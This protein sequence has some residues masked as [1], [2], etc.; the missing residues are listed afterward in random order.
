MTKYLEGPKVYTM[1]HLAKDK[2]KLIREARSLAAQK[3]HLLGQFAISRI[4]TGYPPSTSRGA[5]RAKCRKCGAEVGIDPEHGAVFGEGVED[6][7]PKE[8]DDG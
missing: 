4:V 8:S 5:L 7:C 3:N 2:S 1:S 6:E